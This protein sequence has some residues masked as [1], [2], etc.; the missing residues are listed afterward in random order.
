[1]RKNHLPRADDAIGRIHGRVDPVLAFISRSHRVVLQR[2]LG[3]TR[4]KAGVGFN[5]LKIVVDEVAP[6]VAQSRCRLA[7][8]TLWTADL[9]VAVPAIVVVDGVHRGF[10]ELRRSLEFSPDGWF[11]RYWN[12]PAAWVEIGLS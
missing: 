12:T 2:L 9:A 5:G 3:E 8:G 10:D 11:C 7:R 4:P 1:V 6:E